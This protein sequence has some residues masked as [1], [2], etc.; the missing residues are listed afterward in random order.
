M[1]LLVLFAGTFAQAAL[2][3]LLCAAV[4]I[5]ISSAFAALRPRRHPL[6][7]RRDALSRAARS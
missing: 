2:I 1:N 3:G 6:A 7:R 5:A 4:V